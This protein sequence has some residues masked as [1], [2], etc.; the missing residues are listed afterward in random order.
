MFGFLRGV[1]VGE[2]R[3]VL[4]VQHL[5]T[6][7]AIATNDAAMRRVHFHMRALA[8][9]C[10]WHWHTL[11]WVCSSHQANLVVNAAVCGRVLRAADKNDDVCVACVRL[12]KFAVPDY[13]EDFSAALRYHVAN[14][15]DVR[16]RALET[17][18]S[19]AQTPMSKYAELYGDSVVPADICELF[20]DASP[21]AWRHWCDAGVDHA[22]VRGKC[23]RALHKHFFRVEER[24]IVS[25]LWFSPSA[26]WRCCVCALC[27]YE[28]RCSRH[29]PPLG[30][31]RRCDFAASGVGLGP[32][33]Q[34]VASG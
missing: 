23:F 25:R 9:D 22:G 5:A 1:F 4:R 24:P 34:D 30:K 29:R 19:A 17:P 3:R 7:D 32:R 27:I 14:M 33:V 26:S 20:N 31:S 8:V 2:H 10:G 12:F 21:G 15:F 11:S 13:I 16:T 18:L 28:R 6:G